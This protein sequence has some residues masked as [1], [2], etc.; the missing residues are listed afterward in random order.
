MNNLAQ[1][2]AA[3]TN[4]K[5]MRILTNGFMSVA[6]VSICG[7]IFQLVK[8]IPIGPYQDFL[9]A[10][11]IGNL[12][13]I[14]IAVC[15]DLMALYVVISMGYTVGKEFGQK[16]PFA[17]AIVALGTFF[18]LTPTTATVY[19]ADY[20]QS[21]VASGVL[22]TGVLGARGIFLAIICGLLGS[23]LY[24]FF[25]EK[26]LKFKLPDSVPDNVAGMFE[27]MLPGGLTFLVFLAIRY[28][29]SLTPYGTAQTLIYTILQTPLM[30]IGGGLIGAL[31]FVTIEKLLWCFGVHGGMVCYSALAPIMSAAMAANASAYAA[32]TA[33]P[34]P[35]W[36]WSTML[37]D[38]PVLPLCIAMLI[39]CKSE[40][41]KAL[42]KI[43][44]PT[45]I[46]NISEPQVFGIPVIMN[47]IID[48]P[49]ILLQ[50]V[51]MLLTLLVTKL[52][53]VHQAVGA[54]V[55]NVMPTLIGFAF[56]NA[57][58]TGFVWA[59]VLI[60]LNVIVFIPFVKA[61]DNKALEAEKAAETA[62]AE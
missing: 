35:E 52:G 8:S 3:F 22:S 12:L 47:P 30:S 37:M 11:G 60:V 49:F 54:S 33:V 56:V 58:W 51:N 53:I 20:T 31:A 28:L 32:G 5:W 25:I 39:V 43:S 44:I 1:K 6:A 38:F 55:T 17:P 57:H 21:M 26:D 19:S 15:S 13:S 40:Q 18:V 4:S 45:S 48:I 42:S 34:Y 61:I 24:I 50:P 46:F 10:S 9:A 2:I 41:Y 7:S 59:A 23:R 29:I 36:A 27:M 14:P 62:E 16:N